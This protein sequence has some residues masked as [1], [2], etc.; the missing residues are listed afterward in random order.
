[1]LKDSRVRIPSH[2]FGWHAF[3]LPHVSSVL[4]QS[5]WSCRDV[6]RHIEHH[7]PDVHSKR[8]NYVVMHEVARQATHITEVLAIKVLE[9]IGEEMSDCRQMSSQSS[10]KS[11]WASA[12]RNLRCQKTLLECAH[13]RSS[14]L[15]GRLQN[16]MNLV[17]ESFFERYEILMDSKAFHIGT[18]RDSTIAAQMARAMQQDSTAMKTISVLGL[19]FLPGTFVSA[20][21]SR[22]AC[23]RRLRETM[24]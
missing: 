5:V 18:E 6:I 8:P 20:S 1:M 12:F 13:G 14:A 19:V 10:S 3:V 17:C 22:P 4:D 9:S 16:E 23:T 24:H 2:P 15:T 21:L 7:R 11:E